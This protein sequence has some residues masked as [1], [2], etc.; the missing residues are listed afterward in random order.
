MSNSCKQISREASILQSLLAALRAAQWSHWTSHWQTT[1]G[2]SYGDHLLLERLYTGITEEIDTLAEKLVAYYGPSAVDPVCQARMMSAFLEVNSD[3]NPINR[4]LKVE[5]V[6]MSLFEES[7][8]LLEK[9]GKLPLG[10]NDFIMA[11]AN[12]HETFIYLLK[13]RTR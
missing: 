12:A 10:M 3:D 13:Q 9:A 1:G 7:F 8:S 2:N 6:L 5:T 4:A 11:T